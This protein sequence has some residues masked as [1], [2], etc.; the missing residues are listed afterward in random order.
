MFGE[1]E[2]EGTRNTFIDPDGEFGSSVFIDSLEELDDEPVTFNYMVIPQDMLPDETWRVV[3]RMA[4]QGEDVEIPTS[5]IVGK[6]DLNR[7]FE[8]IDGCTIDRCEALVE[9]CREKVRDLDFDC[10]NSIQDILLLLRS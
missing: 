2:E 8:I 9:S 7:D 1:R 10:I 6:D 4:Y 3:I 5:V